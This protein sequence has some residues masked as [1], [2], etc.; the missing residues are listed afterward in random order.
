[1]KKPLISCVLMLLAGLAAWRPSAAQ[2]APERVEA[3]R[4]V[5]LTFISEKIYRDPFNEVELAAVF[6]TPQGGQLRVPAFWAGESLCGVIT[7][8]PKSS[9]RMSTP[10][11]P[12]CPRM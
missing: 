1:M 5:E 8:W 3:N 10:I 6:R 11:P 2:A 9:T 12:N 4:M 7:I